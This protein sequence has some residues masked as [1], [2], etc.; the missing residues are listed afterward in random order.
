MTMMDP[1]ENR[2][3]LSAMSRGCSLCMSPCR[4]YTCLEIP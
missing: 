1:V 3:A 4:I 2:L